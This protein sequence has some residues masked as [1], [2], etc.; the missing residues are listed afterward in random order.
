MSLSIEELRERL[1][2]RIGID[3]VRRVAK[4]TAPQQLFSLFYDSD[5][6]V[7]RNAAWALTHQDDGAVAMLPHDQLVNFVLSTSNSSLRRLAL[8][9]LERQVFVEDDLRTDFL[10]F[11]LFGMKSLDEPPGVQSLCM[12]LS[13]RMC[14]CYPEL[15]HEFDETLSMMQAECYTPAVRGLIRRLRKMNGI[16]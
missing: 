6:R 11:C 13:H 3:E 9:L 1:A 8:S 10:D 7:A 12:K 14:G 15:Q 2:S 16:R 5:E 4:D